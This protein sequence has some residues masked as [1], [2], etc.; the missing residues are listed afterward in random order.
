M[1]GKYRGWVLH[2]LQLCSY[3]QT[4]RCTPAMAAGVSTTL[5][6]LADMVKALEEWE[7]RASSN[8]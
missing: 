4:L 8:A 6:Q 2:A 7:S 3:L 1:E 5:W